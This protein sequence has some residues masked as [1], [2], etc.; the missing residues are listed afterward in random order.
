MHFITISNTNNESGCVYLSFINN[1]SQ[2]VRI[3]KKNINKGQV[4][5][6]GRVLYP[7]LNS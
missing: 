6:V 3:T 7:T 1:S 5:A 2:G 4:V